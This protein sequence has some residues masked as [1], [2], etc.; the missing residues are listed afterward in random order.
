[1][2]IETPERF[3]VDLLNTLRAER[4][5]PAAWYRFLAHSWSMARETASVHPRLHRSWLRT[6]LALVLLGGGALLATV[7]YDGS[8]AGLRFLPIFAFCIGWQISDLFWHLGLNRPPHSSRLF[9]HLGVANLLTILR[10]FCASLLLARFIAGLTTPISLVLAL[11]LA[12]IITDILD[13]AMARL[14]AARSRLGQILDGEADFCLVLATS[15]ILVRSQILPLWLCL[16]IIARFLVPL[17]AAIFSYFLLARPVRFGST[18]WGK[19]AGLVQCLYFVVLLAPP[20]LAPVVAL[21]NLPLLTLFVALLLIAPLA[22]LCANL[23]FH[24]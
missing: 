17:F 19:G 3:V 7:L 12:G 6:S 9:A 20:Q 13:G 1:M 21:L 10:G 24:E 23:R 16:V 14:F 8:E 15:M 22:Q 18:F 4:F 5:T 2:P 11:F